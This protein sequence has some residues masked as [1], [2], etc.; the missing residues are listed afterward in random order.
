MQ[1]VIVTGKGCDARGAAQGSTPSA[2]VSQGIWECGDR[3]L[4]AWCVE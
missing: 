2:P 3:T 4:K 1:D